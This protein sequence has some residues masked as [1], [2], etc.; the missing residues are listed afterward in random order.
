VAEKPAPAAQQAPSAP[1]LPTAPPVKRAVPSQ[2][3]K[4]AETI[5]SKPVATGKDEAAVPRPKFIE[6]PTKAADAGA[7][8]NQPARGI[9]IHRGSVKPTGGIEIHRGIQPTGAIEIYRGSVRQ[10]AADVAGPDKV[11]TPQPTAVAVTSSAGTQSRSA[12]YRNEA[13][14]LLEQARRR[15]LQGEFLKARQ[16]ARSASTL[17][18]DWEPGEDSPQTFLSEL[19][20]FPGYAEAIGGKA[21][22]VELSAVPGTAK[23]QAA[24]DAALRIEPLRV[25]V[26][27]NA[28]GRQAAESQKPPLGQLSKVDAADQKPS[29]L[30][31]RAGDVAALRPSTPTDRASGGGAAEDQVQVAAGLLPPAPSRGETLFTN[32]LINLITIFAALVFGLFALLSAAMLV[33]K[34]KLKGGGLNLRV[35]LVT[36]RP[37]ATLSVTSGPAP[38]A[39]YVAAPPA[40]PVHAEQTA[41]VSPHDGLDDTDDFD[42]IALAFDPPILSLAE[43][44]AAEEQEMQLKEQAILTQIL[45]QNIELRERLQEMEGQPT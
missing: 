43:Q 42:P 3:A 15:A 17:P 5:E 33:L 44:R 31:R 35:E 19:E 16:L 2:V 8:R 38:A 1:G 26:D 18:V 37:L 9:E 12:F 45:E 34:N 6:I 23:P 13:Q 10:G 24:S 39:T 36:N 40:G 14:T 29:A 22:P 30:G 25:D 4:T 28:A 7:T 27:S 21:L 20:S 11:V 32:V 41:A